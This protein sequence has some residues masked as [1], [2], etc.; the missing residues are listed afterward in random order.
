MLVLNIKYGKLGRNACEFWA[1]LFIE[2]E[3]DLGPYLPTAIVKISSSPACV[4]LKLCWS[5]FE[6]ASGGAPS[7]WEQADGGALRTLL[8]KPGQEMPKVGVQ[9]SARPGRWYT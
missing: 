3:W 9:T 2:K 6:P 4:R 7:G 5:G 8:W 1:L